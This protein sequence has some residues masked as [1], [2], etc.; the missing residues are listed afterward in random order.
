[1]Y[2]LL[3]F[4]NIKVFSVLLIKKIPL[5]GLLL[6]ILHFYIICLIIVKLGNKLTTLISGGK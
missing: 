6:A 5:D 1:M 4:M 2:P 3:L